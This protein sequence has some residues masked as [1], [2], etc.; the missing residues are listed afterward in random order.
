MSGRKTR[1]SKKDISARINAAWDEFEQ[2]LS[3]SMRE[4]LKDGASDE[5][6]DALAAHVGFELGEGFR[7]FYKR[8][9]GQ[10][11]EKLDE[12]EHH[13][14]LF[15]DE[16]WLRSIDEI[17]ENADWAAL[18]YDDL[19][20]GEE[21]LAAM[22][23][24]KAKRAEEDAACA[25][26]GQ[27]PSRGKGGK[28]LMAQTFDDYEAHGIAA[29]EIRRVLTFVV[30]PREEESRGLV[31]AQADGDKQTV[32]AGWAQWSTMYETLDQKQNRAAPSPQGFV[33]WFERF[34][35][36]TANANATKKRKHKQ[37]KEDEDE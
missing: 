9:N 6:L 15:G 33:A 17:I 1:S 11:C 25:A 23:A 32:L 20:P 35:S 30:M 4:S 21:E 28:G 24:A 8:H 16:G 3:K 26:S 29:H 22:R 12:S 14:P 36:R 31:L 10:D 13:S 2:K 7:A 18:Q 19:R 34:V 27:T 37:A 5:Q